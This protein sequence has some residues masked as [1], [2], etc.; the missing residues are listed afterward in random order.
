MAKLMVKVLEAKDEAGLFLLLI[1]NQ[2]LFDMHLSRKDGCSY[3]E[4]M[5]SCIEGHTMM[6]NDVVEERLRMKAARYFGKIE[7]AQLSKRQKARNLQGGFSTME[8]YKGE[9]VLDLGKKSKFAD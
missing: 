3:S 2:L 6:V 5:N 1:P 7:K 9:V 4:K 8:V